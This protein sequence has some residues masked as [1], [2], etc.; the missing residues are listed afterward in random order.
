MPGLVHL[1]IAADDPE[2]AAT[3]YNQV[4]GWT[5]TKL[6]GATPYWLVTPPDGSGPGAGIAKREQPW[7]TVTPTF[8]VASADAMAAAITQKGGTIVV[9]KA[10]VPGVGWLM[11]FRDTEGNILAALEAEPGNPFAGGPRE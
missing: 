5:V 8:E 4:L 11:T 7:Q 6:E 2:R 9:P 10:H 3:F 1:D